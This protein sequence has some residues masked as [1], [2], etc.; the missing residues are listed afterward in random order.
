MK[1][2]SAHNKLPRPKFRNATFLS[3]KFMNVAFLHD[4]VEIEFNGPSTLPPVEEEG[5]MFQNSG[6]R[7][8]GTWQ[9]QW[10]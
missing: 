4:H 1:A 8:Y 6:F 7:Y 5:E 10:Q 2:R 9:L 3:C